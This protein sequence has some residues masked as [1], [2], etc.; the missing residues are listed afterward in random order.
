M[1]M[2]FVWTAVCCLMLGAV[3]A[4]GTEA[5]NKTDAGWDLFAPLGGKKTRCAVPVKNNSF[6]LIRAK[7]AGVWIQPAR[8]DFTPYHAIAFE[9]E[10]NGRPGSGGEMAVVMHW[11]NP[12]NRVS[13]YYFYRM[14][15]SFT[16]KKKWSSRSVIWAG[17]GNLS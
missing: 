10:A 1:K 5:E 7:N 4:A 3:Y 9:I 12:D 16:G 8:A 14:P 15:V 13:S 2:K 17:T 6:Q 11:K